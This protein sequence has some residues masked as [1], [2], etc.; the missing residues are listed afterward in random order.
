MRSRLDRWLVATGLAS[1][2]RSCW[3]RRLFTFAMA[4]PSPAPACSPRRPKLTLWLTA[5]AVGFR[6]GLGFVHFRHDRW[7]YKFSDP[8]V[9]G[10][11]GKALL[12]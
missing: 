8:I 9:R 2:V 12:A 5:W 3:D 11:I 7:I 10:T 6:I 4:R 1:A